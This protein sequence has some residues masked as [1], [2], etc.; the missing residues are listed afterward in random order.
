MLDRLEINRNGI[1][2]VWKDQ[3]LDR[4]EIHRNGIRGVFT[5]AGLGSADFRIM[6]FLGSRAEGFLSAIS[7]RWIPLCNLVQKDSSL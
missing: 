5:H 4:L 1:R 3:V 7:Y 6:S 2:G